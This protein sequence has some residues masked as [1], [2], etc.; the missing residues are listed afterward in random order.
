MRNKE[1]DILSYYATLIEAFS[2]AEEE[3]VEQ[4]DYRS[5]A[6]CRDAVIKFIK[7]YEQEAKIIESNSIAG[8]NDIVNS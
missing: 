1:W 2:E 7:H 8:S 5:A 6:V 3:A 4:E